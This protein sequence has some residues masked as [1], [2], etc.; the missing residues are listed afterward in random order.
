MTSPLRLQLAGSFHLCHNDRSVA[1][2]H[3]GQRL[4]AFLALRRTPADRRRVAAALWCDLEE[5]QAFSRLR[6]TLWRLPTYDD[7]KL[8]AFSGGRLQL[9][10]QLTVDVW[11]A[12]GP[13]AVADSPPEHLC[14][15]LLPDWDDEWVDDERERYRQ[16]RL[17][18]LEEYSVAAEQAGRF[19]A[20][21]RAA[22]AAVSADPLRESAQRRVMQVHIAEDN[23][24]EALRQYDRLRAMLRTEL[25][26]APSPATRAIVTSLLGRPLDLTEAK[27]Q[28]GPARR[29][30]AL[31][32]RT[33]HGIR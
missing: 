13:T 27:H 3:P 24:S 17:H 29:V 21:L 16:L 32:G 26:L 11:A 22:L 10:P 14:A 20:A 8:V 9:S 1:V 18:R 30:G 6:S 5:T 12:E 15:D 31:T 25:G 28:R 19:S 7:G 33:E 4:L 23:P 2:P